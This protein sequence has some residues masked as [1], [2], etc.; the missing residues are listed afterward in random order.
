[1]ADYEHKRGLNSADEFQRLFK[2]HN[3][4]LV[5]VMQAARDL[6]EEHRVR[7]NFLLAMLYEA[8][9]NQADEALG[10]TFVSEE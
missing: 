6:I 7:S 8:V 3:G 1:M 9:Y 4:D 10:P 5:A 2:V